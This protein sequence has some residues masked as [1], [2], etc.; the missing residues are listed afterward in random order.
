MAGFRGPV[1]FFL[2]V[3]PH[4]VASTGSVAG[5]N[6]ICTGVVDTA[7]VT[8]L[9]IAVSSTHTVLDTGECGRI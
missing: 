8:R 5:D 4:Q 1:A 2:D 7:R 9:I 6:T 3:V